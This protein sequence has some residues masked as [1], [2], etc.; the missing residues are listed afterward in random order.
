FAADRGVQNCQFVVNTQE[1]IP[2][3]SASI[4]VVVSFDVLEHI[5]NPVA[6]LSELH[7]VLV[8]GG[9]AFVVFTP[10]Y[11]AFSHH[12]NYV[13]Q[14]PGLHWVFDPQTL[15]NAVNRILRSGGEQRFGT[16]IQPNAPMSFNGKRRCL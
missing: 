1:T 10:Y 5:S 8:P 2:L 14:L 4:D 7:R 15:I 11:G 16:A 13:S 12:L 3:P 9:R 6:M